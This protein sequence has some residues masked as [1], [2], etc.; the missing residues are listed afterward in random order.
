[1]K[2]LVCMLAFAALCAGT[3]FAGPTP[4][5]GVL[6]SPHD[7]NTLAGLQKDLQ[8][9]VCAFCHTPHHAV[10]L[11]G[12]YNPLWSHQPF[13]GAGIPYESAT[14]D[15][16]NNGAIDP[17]IGPSRLCMSCHDGAIAPDQHYGATHLG[18]L[19][20]SGIYASDDFGGIAVGL[21]G[22][23]GN[24]HPIGFDV[25]ESATDVGIFA[26]TFSGRTWKLGGVDGASSVAISA[27]LFDASGVGAGPF[28][29]TCAT[30][31]DVHNQDNVENSVANG[32]G[33]AAHLDEVNGN[34]FVFAPQ[35][36]SQLCLSCH[37]K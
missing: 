26:D 28:Y 32:L 6:N 8:G 14:F 5:S 23:F 30:C 7:I 20:V 18:T 35:S 10:D 25:A 34:Y 22:Y 24:D 11:G 12:E 9:R 4:G 3:A 16:D 21:G 1:M 15:A 37:D 27:G 33:D 2:K 36:G 13:T 29:F 31:H 17:L 19:P